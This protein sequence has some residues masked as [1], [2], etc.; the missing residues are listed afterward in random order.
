MGVDREEIREP[1]A[2]LRPV[3]TWLCLDSSNRQSSNVKP[4]SARLPDPI[5]EQEE[6]EDVTAPLML[7]M[8]R[9]SPLER[10]LPSCCMICLDWGLTRWL[11]P[12]SPMRPPVVKSRRGHAS[13]CAMKNWCA[14]LWVI[15][16]PLPRRPR[17]LR[18]DSGPLVN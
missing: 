13:M 5:V 14:L 10:A 17:P 7:A 8:V 1:E 15:R 12:S 18:S 6:G 11:P 2:F 9:L 16:V 4:I 3:V